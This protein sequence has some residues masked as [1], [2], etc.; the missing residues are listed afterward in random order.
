MFVLGIVMMLSVFGIVHADNVREELCR[1]SRCEFSV[2]G[3]N[4]TRCNVWITSHRNRSCILD[5][6]CYLYGLYDFCYSNSVGSD[7][8]CY[9]F[10]CP[11]TI[12]DGGIM[13]WIGVV[14]LN[15]SI[16]MFALFFASLLY[17]ESR[18]RD[19]SGE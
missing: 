2:A 4:G 15:V 19:K 3:P 16:L 18:C 13:F 11:Y 12:V 6:P 14:L 10:E 1:H 8:T 9:T 7:D 5:Q 17:L